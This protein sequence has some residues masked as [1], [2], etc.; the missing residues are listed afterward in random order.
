M[1]APT[2]I[3][4]YEKAKS[5]R[6]NFDH[7]WQEVADLV[8]RNDV[9]EFLSLQKDHAIT[10]LSLERDAAFALGREV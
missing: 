2:L 7:H 1:D 4:R 9:L 5:K 10:K 8:K 3:S 6:Y